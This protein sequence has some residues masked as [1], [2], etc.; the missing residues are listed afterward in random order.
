MC[1][2]HPRST[3]TIWNALN[4]LIW[5]YFQGDSKAER[6]SGRLP[7]LPFICISLIVSMGSL[8]DSI[9]KVTDLG[10]FA[11]QYHQL[12]YPCSTA[13]GSLAGIFTRQNSELQLINKY[14]QEAS[15]VGSTIIFSCG[16]ISANMEL[17]QFS[18][19][20]CGYSCPCLS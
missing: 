4:D 16:F 19:C 14:N 11:S 13:E 15:H 12:C 5:Q 17:A 18:G 3:L 9:M 20:C 7:G 6:S 2:Y 1:F 10:D 8:G